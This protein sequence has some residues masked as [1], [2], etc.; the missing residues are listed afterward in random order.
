VYDKK[1]SNPKEKEDREKEKRRLKSLGKRREK[2][3][4]EM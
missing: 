1:T 4:E 2:R 3:T